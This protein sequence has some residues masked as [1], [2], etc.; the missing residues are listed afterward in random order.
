MCVLHFKVSHHSANINK[1]K[2]DDEGLMFS[3]SEVG[4]TE[5]QFTSAATVK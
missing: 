2:T 4:W 3:G 1:E 5:N